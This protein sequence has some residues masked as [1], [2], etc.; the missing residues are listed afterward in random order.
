MEP[1]PLQHF[2]LHKLYSHITHQNKRGVVCTMSTTPT[3]AELGGTLPEK[4]S[5]NTMDEEV[6]KFIP[7]YWVSG[8]WKYEVENVEMYK[9]G[10]LSLYILR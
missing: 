6:Q 4:P 10:G 2:T 3:P 5:V 7:K 9:P 8:F 1:K